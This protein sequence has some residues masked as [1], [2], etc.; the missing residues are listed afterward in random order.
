MTIQN[1]IRTSGRTSGESRITVQTAEATHS[2]NWGRVVVTLEVRDGPAQ[3]DE[4][5][6]PWEVSER[7]VVSLAELAVLFGEA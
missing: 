5:D 6:A 7:K 1:F 3:G 2:T 4:S